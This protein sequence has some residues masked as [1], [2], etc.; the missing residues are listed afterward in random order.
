[1]KQTKKILIWGSGFFFVSLVFCS[2]SFATPSIAEIMEEI[3]ETL[4]N[5]LNLT[6]EQMAVIQA[7]LD[8]Q[9]TQ[10]KVYADQ[11]K[12]KKQAIEDEMSSGEVD[13]ATV[14]ALTAELNSIREDVLTLRKNTANNIKS[15]LT[16][17][18]LEI[19]DDIKVNEAKK[20]EPPDV[21]SVKFFSVA[22]DAE[23]FMPNWSGEEITITEELINDFV[24]GEDQCDYSSGVTMQWGDQDV[25]F[26]P[27]T[28]VG[29]APATSGW[30][31]S[32]ATG[33]V[34]GVA[35]NNIEIADMTAI[36]FRAVM[37]LGYYPFSGAG[38]VS[39]EFYC[40]DD[41]LGYDNQEMV[42]SPVAG[43]TYNCV[44]FTVQ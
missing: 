19:I 40:Y 34:N 43:S 37:E 5:R 10:R 23:A 29:A 32:G 35:I 31:E 11:E 20:L 1:M 39:S 33:G 13:V 44:L 17:E 8:N 3:T 28:Y 38:N 24:M 6:P 27:Y 16:A 41:V 14:D 9:K 26:Y 7:E 36:K 18:Q 2:V 30:I 22:C 42:S 15:V 12:V 4:E 25:N 21:I